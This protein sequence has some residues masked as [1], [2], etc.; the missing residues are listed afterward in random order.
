[1]NAGFGNDF[2]DD[3]QK[4]CPPIDDTQ[5]SSSNNCIRLSVN[6]QIFRGHNQTPIGVTVRTAKLLEDEED[7]RKEQAA[8]SDDADNDGAL[9][10]D[11]YRRAHDA[12]RIA[13]AQGRSDSPVAQAPPLP[14]DDSTTD[15]STAL[16]QRTVG[17]NSHSQPQQ[18]QQPLAQ[19][20]P[21]TVDDGGSDSEDE[22]DDD[23]EDE[24]DDVQ[25]QLSAPHLFTFLSSHNVLPE[26]AVASVTSSTRFGRPVV[27]ITIPAIVAKVPRLPNNPLAAELVQRWREVT[28]TPDVFKAWTLGNTG[29]V[30]IKVK[31]KNFDVREHLFKLYQA[32]WENRTNPTDYYTST[33]Q[34]LFPSEKLLAAMFG[35]AAACEFFLSEPMKGSGAL[36]Q[37]HIVCALCG[38]GFCLRSNAKRYTAKDYDERTHVHPV[39]SPLLYV[40]E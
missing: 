36:Q 7:D 26:G 5:K 27:N 29:A 9:H 3:L 30:M 38:G 15:S 22:V 4:N 6:T 11:K 16:L 20:A 10:A 32:R 13:A 2:Y 35:N 37:E 1:M 33:Q 39:Y 34:F 24:V 23:S 31:G 18:H 8:D 12:T 40:W 21:P 17:I 14:D 19:H 25:D 28:D